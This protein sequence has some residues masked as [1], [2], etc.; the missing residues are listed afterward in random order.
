MLPNPSPEQM[1]MWKRIEDSLTEEDVKN[2]ADFVGLSD[3][4]RKRAA[5]SATSQ[6]LAKISKGYRLTPEIAVRLARITGL[7]LMG[8]MSGDEFTQTIREQCGLG[9]TTA[10]RLIKLVGQPQAKAEPA[11]TTAP[12]PPL[13]GNIVNLKE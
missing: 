1:A 4:A 9:A 6:E 7:M 10:R 11:E 13:S 12:E 8:A 2:K 3:D 5:A